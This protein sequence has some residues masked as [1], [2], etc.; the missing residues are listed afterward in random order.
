MG[1]LDLN[2][3]L[4]LF[5]SYK[6]FEK[7]KLVLQARSLR[8]MRPPPK[9]SAER[10]KKCREKKKAS[11]P[12]FRHQE[13]ERHKSFRES[14]TPESKKKKAKQA[15]AR[16]EKLRERKRLAK[17]QDIIDEPAYPTLASR[18]KAVSRYVLF[19]YDY[20]YIHRSIAGLTSPLKT[21]LFT[22]LIVVCPI[23][24]L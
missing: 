14:L 9:S 19:V 21:F 6:F 4:T 7:F 18:M 3:L 5:I 20:S 1:L 17:Q 10:S 15:N 16:M 24:C 2:M 12:G 13:N 8:T 22:G 11:V 23:T